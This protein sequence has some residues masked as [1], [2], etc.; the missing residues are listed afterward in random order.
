[1]KT[2]KTVSIAIC[3]FALLAVTAYAQN[4]GLRADVPFPFRAGDVLL[5]AGEYNVGVDITNRVDVRSTTSVAGTYLWSHVS[6]A[7]AVTEQATLTFHRYGENYFLK[8]IAVAGRADT[9]EL[10]ATSAEREMAKAAQPV[11]V[12]FRLS[13]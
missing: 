12:A 8:R 4:N 10:P 13:K 11:V 3:L 9:F 5:P 1:M 2:F 6:Q 7:P